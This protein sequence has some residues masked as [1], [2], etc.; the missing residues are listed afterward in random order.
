MSLGSGRD[1][2]V[3][4]YGAPAGLV[5]RRAEVWPALCDLERPTNG[6]SAPVEVNVGPFEAQELPLP[7]T[8]VEGHDVEG[9]VTR[10]SCGLK[11]RLCL[12]WGELR[13]FSVAYGARP[14]PGSYVAGWPDPILCTTH[15]E[16]LCTDCSS[17]DSPIAPDVWCDRASMAANSAGLRYPSAPCGLLWL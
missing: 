1:G 14:L 8:G 2:P 6:E 3:E 4:G 9:L 7:Q 17:F 12:L 16:S 5:L 10:P 11:Q 15:D 13:L